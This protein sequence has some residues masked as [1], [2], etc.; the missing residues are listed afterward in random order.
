MTLETF[1]SF[2]LYLKVLVPGYV[3][4]QKAPLFRN[5]W[6]KKNPDLLK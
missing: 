4:L 6:F 2:E 1:L 5:V 3:Q